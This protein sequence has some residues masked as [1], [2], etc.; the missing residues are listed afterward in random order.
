[1]RAFRIWRFPGQGEL[2]GQPGPQDYGRSHADGANLLAE[3][4]APYNGV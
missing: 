4:L 2:G 3:A 1:M